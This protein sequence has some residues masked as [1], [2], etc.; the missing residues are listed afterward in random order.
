MTCLNHTQQALSI[1]QAAKSSNN[2][3]AK[4]ANALNHGGL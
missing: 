3:N 2:P 4:L 1:P